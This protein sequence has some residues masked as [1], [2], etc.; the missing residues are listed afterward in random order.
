MIHYIHQSLRYQKLGVRM[1]NGLEGRL[2]LGNGR[3]E[4]EILVLDHVR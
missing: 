2:G 3:R 1:E 4:S